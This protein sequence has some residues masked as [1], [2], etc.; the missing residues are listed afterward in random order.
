MKVTQIKWM[1]VIA[2]L[3]LV[4]VFASCSSGS[5]QVSLRSGQDGAGGFTAVSYSG[6]STPKVMVMHSPYKGSSQ[7]AP[8][9]A[10]DLI[11]AQQSDNPIVNA[12]LQCH[13]PFEELAKKTAGF[14]NDWG[15][16]VNPHVYV[17]ISL[18][19]P[20]ASTNIISCLE[21]HEQH[22][23]PVT[24]NMQVK[25]GTVNW[26]YNCHH[27]EEFRSCSDCH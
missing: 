12:C 11:L 13:G 6:N 15:V 17:D 23:I 5:S 10:V 20:H 27:D 25:P 19:N 8:V 1:C 16:T 14:V 24:A 2:C 4:A 18:G 26:C 3:L 22:P 21:C 7:T 9:S